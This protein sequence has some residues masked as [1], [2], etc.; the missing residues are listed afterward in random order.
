MMMKDIRAG[1]VG[2][3]V[4][5]RCIIGAVLSTVMSNVIVSLSSDRPYIEYRKTVVKVLLYSE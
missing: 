2:R 4:E 3:I 5:H 1:M